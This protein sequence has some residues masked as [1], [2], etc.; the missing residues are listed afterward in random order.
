MCWP[1]N[2][3]TT[4]TKVLGVI[5]LLTVVLL[6]G[7]IYFLSRGS[8]ST[9]PQVI[10]STTVSQIDYSKGEK[11]GSDSAKVKVVEFSDFECPACLTAEPFAKR[12]RSSYQPDQ[13]Q[14]IYRHFPLM[15][16][17]H[18]RVAAA[19]AEAAGQQGKFWEMHDK[20]FETQTQWSPM[21]NATAFFMDLVKQLD[22]DE[23][24]IRQDMES[25]AIKSKVE[26]DTA[27]ANRLRINQTPTFLVN[28]RALKMRSYEDLNTA[29]TEELQKQQVLQ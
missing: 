8:F 7:G 11:I 15:Q 12:I 25:G 26:A 19:L 28:G 5:F 21:D 9:S 4:E 20:L 10:E 27:E 18:S 6:F 23:T 17:R 14:F 3:M 13:V 24:K 29:V 1:V 16:H 2:T 22:L